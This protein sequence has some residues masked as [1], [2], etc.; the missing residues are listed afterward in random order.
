MDLINSLLIEKI[1]D[2]GKVCGVF[3]IPSNGKNATNFFPY[4]IRHL[5]GSYDNKYEWNLKKYV[6]QGKKKK[7]VYYS[8][9]ENGLK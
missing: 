3:L 9:N 2:V 5:Y 7:S 1:L 4:L 6:Q 8:A